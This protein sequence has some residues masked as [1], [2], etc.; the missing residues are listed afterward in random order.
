MDNFTKIL[1]PFACNGPASADEAKR[2]VCRW[3][4]KTDTGAEQKSRLKW[5]PRRMGDGYLLESIA[6]KLNEEGDESIGRAFALDPAVRRALALP[7]DERT[8]VTLTARS[9]QTFLFR[10]GN[11]G[12]YLFETNVGFLEFEIFPEGGA[13]EYVECN[14]FFS[15]L[16]DEHNVCSF[17]KKT[18]E[19][20]ETVSFTVEKKAKELLSEV[21]DLR[22]FDRGSRL[23][24]AD[25]KPN[26]FGLYRCADEAEFNGNFL[27]L[28]K[29]NFK[30]SYRVRTDGDVFTEFENIVCGATVNGCFDFLAPAAEQE[31]NGFML[32]GFAENFAS[33]YF[34]LYLLLLNERFTLLKRLD[35]LNAVDLRCNMHSDESIAEAQAQILRLNRKSA[36]LAARCDFDAV[37]SQENINRWYAYVKEK[38]C[39]RKLLA[40]IDGKYAVSERLVR[41]YAD[42][43]ESRRRQAEERAAL[44]KTVSD[45]KLQI[46]A[47]ILAN[48]VGSLSVYSSALSILEFLGVA[49]DSAWMALPAAVTA[50]FFLWLAAETV[51]RVRELIN[52]CKKRDA[53]SE[54]N[55]KKEEKLFSEKTKEEGEKDA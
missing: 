54:N 47:F 16:K 42:E 52:T 1:L 22:G 35:Q 15:E 17:V 14:Y 32:H 12:L 28:A 25:C 10:L 48:I 43:L 38:L 31:K 34:Y 3:E 51:L 18:R 45:L 23:R 5:Q 21:V 30:R 39:V 53:M 11:I 20:E 29:N 13:A 6:D 8:P 27:T 33:R 40:E 7:P 50:L 24:F 26:L 36:M 9:G 19:G 2:A 4:K 41:L 55:G 37:S 49:P 46:L 44:K